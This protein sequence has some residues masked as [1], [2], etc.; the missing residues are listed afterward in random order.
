[1]KYNGTV[2][3][4]RILIEKDLKLQKDVFHN[5][6]EFNIAF[7]HVWHDGLWQ[8]FREFSVDN[9]IFQVI[10]ALFKDVSS[11]VL[12]GKQMGDSSGQ[13]TTSRENH[14]KTQKP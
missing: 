7:V 2:F 12:Q 1:M 14:A 11:A 8:I 3:N 4:C 5:F 9:G 10:Q 6:A 13:L